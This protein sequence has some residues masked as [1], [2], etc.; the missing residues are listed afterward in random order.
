MP[1]AAPYATTQLTAVPK[2][3]ARAHCQ[4]VPRDP[5]TGNAL[6]SATVN[7]YQPGT[8]TPVTGT[9]YD[10]SGNVLANPLTTD[11]VTGLLVFYMATPQNVDLN[12]AHTGYVTQTYSN[13]PVIPDPSLASGAAL[14]K[15][16]SLLYAGAP[17]TPGQVAPGP[18]A[19]ILQMRNGL[20]T[21]QTPVSGLLA[22]NGMKVV[23][24]DMA[25]P[26]GAVSAGNGFTGTL[27]TGAQPNIT[28]LGTLS[29]LTVSGTV[30]A[31]TVATGTV[32][33]G[34]G[35]LALRAATGASGVAI[36]VGTGLTIS[37]GALSVTSGN[38]ST[39]GAGHA[40]ISGAYLS[41]G[42]AASTNTGDITSNRGDGTGTLY[43]GST[44]S[45]YLQYDGTN[46]QLPATSL[47]VNSSQVPTLA[48]GAAFSNGPFSSDW[49]RNTVTGQGMLNT[50]SGRGGYFGSS[51]LVDYPSGYTYWHTGNAGTIPASTVVGI[52]DTQTLTNKTLT[53]PHMTGPI[54]DSGGLT[55][56]AG[57]IGLNNSVFSS[58]GVNV[59]GTLTSGSWPAGVSVTTIGDSGSVTGVDGVKSQPGTL[60][61]SFTTST[62][63]AFHALNPVKG[64]GSTM[65]AVYGVLVESM[66]AGGTNNYG[67][68]IQAP[69]GASSSNIGLLNLGSTQLSGNV[70][71]GTTPPT[72]VTFLNSGSTQLSGNTAVGNAQSPV[73]SV[74][75]LIAA[76]ESSN[77]GSANAL[78]IGGT[79]LTSTQNSDQLT[80]LQISNLTMNLASH[81]GSTLAS[82]RV[83]TPTLQNPSGTGSTYA[84][85]LIDAC[86]QL[87]GGTSSGVTIGTVSGANA[88]NFGLQVL[89]PSGATG[90]NANIYAPTGIGAV[91]MLLSGSATSVY[92]IGINSGE[93]VLMC[94][95]NQLV[96][97]RDSTPTG[98][99]GMEFKPSTGEMVAAGVNGGLLVQTTSANAGTGAGQLF[100]GSL[101]ASGA[102]AGSNG[103]PPSQVAGYFVWGV[104]GAT[105]KV[106]YYAN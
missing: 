93:L 48:N 64:A 78:L 71:I 51:G 80:A 86:G 42:T 34:S 49:F 1:S 18:E 69:S 70:G 23:S 35:G 66:T 85:L 60:A 39:S 31:G 97:V 103:A 17:N 102:N 43:L 72:S 56:V 76:S 101:T 50:S 13:V 54:V 74:A 29:A 104:G 15:V 63:T 46:Y 11:P 37:A 99:L 8:T 105:V 20:P 57:T 77:G 96:T 33:P 65:T 58:I 88:N 41:A 4:M 68:Y 79:T 19:A 12:V 28:S 53:T 25:V 24:G 89:Q 75:L 47:F 95:T 52:N 27:N 82:I 98:T 87:V 83:S 91:G 84:G 36:D 30:T 16:G 45:R 90:A 14:S 2:I 26:A 40:I 9:L 81:T 5:S 22:E 21:W 94:G 61:A 38:I 10:A 7:V 92:G 106:P 3:Q 73:S 6:P 62:V 59:A 44:G 100:M 32:Q 55:I 67:V